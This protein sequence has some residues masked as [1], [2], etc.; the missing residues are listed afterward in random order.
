MDEDV[1]KRAEMRELRKIVRGGR[2]AGLIV[3]AGA[4]CA[5]VLLL[6]F[7]ETGGLLRG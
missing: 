7:G 5:I 1:E 2:A 6:F 4:L 3:A